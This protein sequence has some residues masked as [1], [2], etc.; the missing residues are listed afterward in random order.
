MN[1]ESASAQALADWLEWLEGLHP[2]EIDLGLERVGHVAAALGVATPAARVVTV[3]GTN[4]KGSVCQL[5]AA[6][7]GAA[8]HRVGLYTSPHLSRFNERIRVDGRDADDATLL[9]AFR[10]VEH[11]RGATSLTFFEFTTLAALD[12]FAHAR[13]D[14]I[15]LEVGLGGRLDATNVVDSDVAVVTSIGIDHAEW[16]GTDRAAIARE[17]AGIARA[18]RPLIVGEA[19]PAPGL[20]EAADE[21]GARV[22]RVGHDFA[23]AA[24]GEGW[25]W[26]QD[27]H[28]PVALPLPG[29]GGG[30]QLANAATAVAAVAALGLD[31][32]APGIAA[33]LREARVPG[34][35]EILRSEAPGGTV[36]M[37]LDVA[38][39]PAAASMLAQQLARPTGGRT[40]AVLGM[41][42]DKDIEAV[43][44]ELA[45]VVDA[46]F[47]A[48]LPSPRGAA[49]ER[50]S[51]AIGAIGGVIEA[52]GADPAT[53]FLSARAAVRP[54]DR[55][56]VAGSF[57]T[58]GPVRA[59]LL[60][61]G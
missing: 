20:L 35:F 15:V 19:P 54:G 52:S 41:Y 22:R 27:A 46:W 31:P 16:L 44:A 28:A 23:Y 40:L 2:Q 9:A 58:V 59:L 30:Y 37:V 26:W 17:K 29:A 48:S 50:L 56:V 53:A 7:L 45:P 12:V 49:H 10:R 42:A 6:M 43:V 11:A 38:H 14:V 61:N 1:L 4:G 21:V 24:D 18:D 39:N 8:G 51:Q 25:H 33:G 13:V 47:V 32:A 3:A 55:I 5:V 57:A 36:E 34:R 60:S